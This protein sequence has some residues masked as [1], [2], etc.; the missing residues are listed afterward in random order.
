MRPDV[1]PA[2]RQHAVSRT[3]WACGLVVRVNSG[4]GDQSWVGFVFYWLGI[5]SLGVSLACA[6]Q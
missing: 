4:Y 5:E 2:L 1:C 6:R 3:D